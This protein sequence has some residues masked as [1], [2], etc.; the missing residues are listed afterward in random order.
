MEAASI[1]VLKGPQ[2]DPD[3]VTRRAAAWV[4]SG[5]IPALDWNCERQTVAIATVLFELYDRGGVR[6]RDML[7]ALFDKLATG[8][9]ALIDRIIED[10]REGTPVLVLTHWGTADGRAATS[11][12]VKLT[13]SLDEPILAPGDEWEPLLEGVLSLAPLFDKL[14]ESSVVPFS[15]ASR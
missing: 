14:I 3:S 12:H 7:R 6:S 2:R 5:I 1:N 4:R 8:E 11:F 10:A 15:K 9:P 13:A